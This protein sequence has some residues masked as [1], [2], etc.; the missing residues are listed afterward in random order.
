MRAIT[1]EV[2]MVYVPPNQSGSKV[3]FKSRYA[4]FIGGQWKE[5]AK[6][7]YFE[8]VTPVTPARKSAALTSARHSGRMMAVIN[9]MVGAFPWAKVKG[10]MVG[11]RFWRAIA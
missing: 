7:Q 11:L 3:Q 2:S 10:D 1:Q 4:N 9:F 5:P 8:N 6:G